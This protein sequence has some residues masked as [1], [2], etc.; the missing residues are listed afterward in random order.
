MSN[1]KNANVLRV[2]MGGTVLGAG[3]SLSIAADRSWTNLGG[4]NIWTRDNNWVNDTQ[5]GSS[6]RALFATGSNGS[7]VA[8]R[9]AGDDTAEVGTIVFTASQ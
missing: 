4:D 7:V 1:R 9:S 3:M 2:L 8:I 6:D 5:P